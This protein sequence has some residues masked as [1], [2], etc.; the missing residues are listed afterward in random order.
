MKQILKISNKCV[1]IL[2]RGLVFMGLWVIMH[3]R[4]SSCHN[5]LNIKALWVYCG[6]TGS[7]SN[8]E[9]RHL[10]KGKICPL[11]PRKYP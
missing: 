8:L 3:V 7:L 2:E 9:L 11:F 4:E 1:Q 10:Q 6:Y 5:S